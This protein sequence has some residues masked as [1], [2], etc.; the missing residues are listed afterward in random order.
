[1]YKLW[2][3]TTL[4]T[5]I[6]LTEKKVFHML[7]GGIKIKETQSIIVIIGNDNKLFIPHDII[8]TNTPTDIQNFIN[9]MHQGGITPEKICFAINPGQVENAQAFK[10][11]FQLLA[12][13]RY[14]VR[15][16]NVAHKNY[17][18][19]IVTKSRGADEVTTGLAIYL[20][21]H[22]SETESF[23][24]SD[25]SLS[26]YFYGSTFSFYIIIFYFAIFSNFLLNIS[27]YDIFHLL[28]LL[29]LI[30]SFCIPTIDAYRRWKLTKDNF[31]AFILNRYGIQYCIS[32]NFLGP[33]KLK[34]VHFYPWSSIYKIEQNEL[35]FLQRRSAIENEETYYIYIKQQPTLTL[36]FW[37]INRET[38]SNLNILKLYKN[39]FSE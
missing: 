13:A 12:Q 18:P 33:K 29:G 19:I 10:N 36:N 9:S 35:S 8:I 4:Q 24:N 6:L 7:Y 22:F 1:M 26:Y 2:L 16:I 34:Q 14:E 15:I 25:Y 31:P 23:L 32:N 17:K 27:I 5:L 30:V 38:A 28:V 21:K 39:L 20:K 37:H 3:F 11:F